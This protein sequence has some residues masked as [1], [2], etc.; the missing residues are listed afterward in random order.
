MKTFAVYNIKGGVG[1]TTSTVNLAYLSASEGKRTLIWDLDSQAGTSFYLCV[2]PHIKGGA[3]ELLDGHVAMKSLMRMTGYPN[4]DLLP[5]DFSYRRIDQHLHDVP[6][7]VRVLEKLLKPM[8]RHYDHIFLDCPPGL[9]Y[10]AETVFKTADVLLIPL[11][12]TTLSL[13]A[14]NRLVNFLIENKP[15]HLQVVPFFTMLEAR[16]AIHSAI[17]KNVGEKHEIF[18]DTAIPH[19][20]II[21]AMGVKRSPIFTYAKDSPEADAYR[22]LWQ[23]IKTRT[24]VDV[25][26]KA[27]G[28]KGG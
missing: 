3:K 5:A 16:N 24:R 23:E 22:Q 12:P 15:P 17:S 28:K 14:Y 13:R 9:S 10:L 18:L 4:L 6:R 21:E 2:R 11:I 7:P 27:S 25:V 26:A 20:T 19:S 8:A 1:K